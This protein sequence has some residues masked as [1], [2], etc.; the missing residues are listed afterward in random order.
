MA[1]S[2]RI[3][4]SPRLWGRC[5]R[6]PGTTSEA[7]PRTSDASRRRGR[8]PGPS[9][10]VPSSSRRGGTGWC[11]W[12]T[13]RAADRGPYAPAG[14][15]TGGK[16][17]RGPL[18]SFVRA[19]D[20]L[21]RGGGG[22][23]AFTQDLGFAF[24]ALRK[25]PGFTLVAVLTLA[26]GIGAATA[27]FSVATACSCSAPVRRPRPGGHHLEQLGQLPRQDVGVGGRVPG[28]RPGQPV[29]RGP[30]PL[31]RRTARTSPIPTTPSA[32]ARPA[33][34]PTPSPCSAWSPCSAGRSP[35]RRPRRRR[36]SCS[37][38]TTSGSGASTA[39]RPGRA[40]RR[41]RRHEP[42]GARHP[43]QG[44]VL[45]VDYGSPAEPGLRSRR[46][47]ATPPAPVRTIGG[48]HGSTWSPG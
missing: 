30:G 11:A 2:W 6:C 44:F 4:L 38:A 41:D 48:N 36:P 1:A 3:E 9:A 24:R 16:G 26:L 7:W 23:G 21:Q 12:W 29:L 5:A 20:G 19:L 35:G 28:V 22:M 25:A 46:W 17:R 10:L 47:T 33:S 18:G 34:R 42:D 39:T 37:S 15:G 40:E 13:R 32:S 43:P 31:L 8:R 45:P 27:I 14:R